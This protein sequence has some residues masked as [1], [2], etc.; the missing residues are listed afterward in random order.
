MAY[1]DILGFLWNAGSDSTFK[2]T[3]TDVGNLEFN[4]IDSETH[5]WKRDVTTNPVENGAPIADHIIDQPDT[6]SITGMISNAPILGLVNQVSGLIDGTAL[7]QDYVAQAFD[8]LDALR[9]S[10]Q[11]VTIYTRYKTYTNMVLQSVNIPRTPDGGDA[12]VFTI[13]AVNVRIVTSQKTTIPTGLGVN[14]QSTSTKKAGASN[15]TDSDTQKRVSGNNSN[16]K[17][18]SDKGLL[19]AIHDGGASIKSKVT[20]V[21]TKFWGGP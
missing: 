1:S 16:G 6:L 15:S 17:S 2:L 12:V 21:V 18:G 11:L 19:E 10:K 20:D 3:D 8:V 9:K 14:K 5:D 4:T 7:N 13:Q